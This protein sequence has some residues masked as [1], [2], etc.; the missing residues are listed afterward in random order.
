M[1]S[2]PSA[3]R[4]RPN[5]EWGVHGDETGTNERTNE[6]WVTQD[7]D[8]KGRLTQDTH[9]GTRGQACDSLFAC[10]ELCVLQWLYTYS[11]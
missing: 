11:T 7:T 5:S 9:R 2:E 6:Y 10:A 8:G 4:N 3:A 1:R